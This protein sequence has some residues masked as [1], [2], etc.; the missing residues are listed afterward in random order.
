MGCSTRTA[1]I[2]SPPRRRS[3]G[4]CGDGLTIW[5]AWARPIGRAGLRTTGEGLVRLGLS[6]RIVQ[7]RLSVRV[8]LA[9]PFSIGLPRTRDPGVRLALDVEHRLAWKSLETLQDSFWQ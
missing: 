1:S 8:E 6:R 2:G 5:W 9:Q 3:S 7:R 4:R